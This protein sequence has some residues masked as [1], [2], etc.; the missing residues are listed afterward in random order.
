MPSENSFISYICET[1]LNGQWTPGQT[2]TTATPP[3]VT[4]S[5]PSPDIS[6]S[7]DK[8]N[9]VGFIILVVVIL[10][11]IVLVVSVV[12]GVYCWR[13]KKAT[14]KQFLQLQDTDDF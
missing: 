10:F 3:L 1:L 7:T 6:V 2:F 4:T 9:L 8:S 12:V 13:K 5:S 11:L 14:P